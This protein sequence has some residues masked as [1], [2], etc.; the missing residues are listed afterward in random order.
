MEQ[1]ERRTDWTV[2]AA[3]A[4]IALGVW[5][6]L[7]NV[8]PGFTYYVRRAAAILWPLALIGLGLLLYF[9]AQRG[10]F[11]G[12]DIS[13]KRLYRS[14]DSR[15]IGGVLGGLG[16]F[17][18]VDPTWLR[19]GY[20]IFGVLTWFWPSVVIYVIAMIIVPEQ[21]V[22]GVVE[23]T[24]WPTTGEARVSPPASPSTGWPHATGTETV[25][26]PPP[27]PAA[28]GPPDAEPP[29]EHGPAQS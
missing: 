15:M 23:P 20:V 27:P 22:G 26:T 19:I 4:L 1:H 11:R 24:V 17:L 10:T 29:G 6:L 16:D 13:G 25:Q 28:P 3:I 2:I 8:L 18:G 9:S 14:R 7:G 21:P 12:A 5:F